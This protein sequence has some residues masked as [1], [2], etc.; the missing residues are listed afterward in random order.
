M[1]RKKQ[2]KEP[3]T[4]DDDLK[5]IYGN[6]LNKKYE[7]DFVHVQRRG[8]RGLTSVLGWTL[9]I[10]VLVSGLAWGGYLKFGNP[11]LTND[12]EKLDVT[13]E[14][15]DEVVSGRPVKYEI[16]YANTGRLPIASLSL[17]L[18]T[19]AGLTITSTNPAP[20]NDQ[21]EWLV[22]SVTNGSDGVI[23]VEG[24]WVDPVPSVQT[25]QVVSSYRPA[26]FNADFQ[27]IK[28]KTVN[29]STS[30]LA[31][32]TE[33]IDKAKVG[34][35]M[36]YIF[37]VKNE[38]GVAVSGVHVRLD[39]PEVFT[40][41]KAEPTPPGA[42]AEWITGSIDPQ[43]TYEVKVTGSFTSDAVGLQGI[44]GH[45]GYMRDTSFLEQAFVVAQ[46]DVEASDVKVSLIAN[47]STTDQ[48]ID[49]S[50]TLRV[51][52][53]ADVGAEKN[54]SLSLVFASDS[55]IPINWSRAE[56]DGGTKKNGT[57]TWADTTKADLSLPVTTSGT[58]F[59]LTAIVTVGELTI[60]S[61]P[62]T[63]QVNSDL[64][65]SASAHY[66]VDDA[67]VGEGPLPPTVGKKTT[68]RVY[69]ELTN[70]AHPLTDIVV[71]ATVPT[72]ANFELTRETSTGTVD[73]DKTSRTL[74]WV[75]NALSREQSSV[76][77]S[78][79]ISVTPT[80]DDIG[81]SLKLLNET[82]VTATDT[83]THGT[84]DRSASALTTNV[85]DPGAESKGVVGG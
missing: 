43:G 74:T 35:S 7:T 65:L 54:V 14:G 37:R 80:S 29:V 55:T 48:T 21:K 23:V 63:V 52:V 10:L 36:T 13:I 46:T 72:S 26:N 68:Y 83:E 84:M 50:D 16:R 61:S 78:F 44:M 41:S 6:T 17:H 57:I 51:S 25:L 58:K 11:F 70:S 73:Y 38:G 3:E 30:T 40:V 1:L 9:G 85:N 34:V 18:I 82:R 4:L 79:D 81:N 62:M 76:S 47:G 75:I 66:F 8:R 59:T 32:E 31:L 69:W 19:P 71:K 49:P 15:A 56:L 12:T 67:P 42:G 33:G 45:V 64:S 5:I 53:S 77:T 60:R 24:T 2:K 22:G 28:T 27:D 20:T 39:I